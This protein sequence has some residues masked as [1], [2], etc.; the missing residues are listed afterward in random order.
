MADFQKKF[1]DKSGNTWEDRHQP[2]KSKKYT[3]IER[4]YEPDSSSDDED[5]PG[6]GSRRGSKLSL[7]E[8][9]GVQSKLELPV[10]QLMQ[11]IF[12]AQYFKEVMADMNYD[13]D[14]LPLGKL[15]KRTIEQGYEQLKVSGHSEKS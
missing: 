11:L 4:N 6:A 15:S 8:E 3:F 1:K 7:K 13:T 2:P 10:Q 14:K 5:L 9:E 12:D